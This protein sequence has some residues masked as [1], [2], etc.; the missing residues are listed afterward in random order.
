MNPSLLPPDAR[1]VL[2]AV[3]SSV[4]FDYRLAAADLACT[5]AHVRMLARLGVYHAEESEQ[6]QA[7]VST[8]ADD[9]GQGRFVCNPEL[10]DVHMNV[11]A[12]V[13]AQA[14]TLA[15]RIG[16]ARGRNDLAVTTLRM[17]VRQHCDD[18]IGQLLGLV[19]AFVHQ[20]ERH[21]A[22]VMPGMTHLQAAQPVT[23][24]HLCLA[25]AEMFYRDA[26]RFLQARDWLNESPLGAC[27]LAGTS[28][29]I[30]REA[31]ARE[32]G[33]VQATAN[34]IDS[35]ADR[36]FVLDFLGA[37]ATSS[38]HASRFAEDVLIWL[39]P[40]FGFLS[41]PDFLAG[42]SAIMPHKRNPDALEL[43]RAKSGRIA[44]SLH[45]VQM[46]LKG[47]SMSYC[48]DL[49]EDKEATFDAA[50]SIAFVLDV[51]RMVVDHLEVHPKAMREAAAA[52][53]TTSTDFADW[54][55]RERGVPFRQAHHWVSALVDLARRQ[56]CSLAD[57]PPS[58]RA[59]VDPSLGL[60]TWPRFTPEESVA[61]RTSAGGTAPERVLE[62]MRA[63]SERTR[64]LR[65]THHEIL[66]KAAK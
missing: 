53:F 22:T 59:Q 48:R 44:G 27:A 42:R 57:L 9:V 38:I 63:L 24:G 18:T 29:P 51:L 15:E 16:T 50:Q 60:G 28:F 65:D 32:L 2:D 35:V 12:A 7:G 37:C 66:S 3:N 36:D 13:A 43:V 61:S 49:Q 23:F 45:A 10:E 20:A 17:W 31:M 11:E 19:E 25:Y 64:S 52:G 62:A 26:R 40:Q 5:A 58:V 21:A 14:G 1:R 46:V 6:V 55:V 8:V 4:H 33:F 56:G 54:L 34:S 30:D 47:L 41:L 39:T